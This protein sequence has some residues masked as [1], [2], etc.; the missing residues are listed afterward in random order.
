MLKRRIEVVPYDPQWPVIFATGS[1]QVPCSPAGDHHSHSPYGQHG[2]PR[3]QCQT[4]NRL[5]GRGKRHRGN[6]F[7]QPGDA[8]A[9]LPPT[10]RI[11]NPRTTLFQQEFGWNPYAS[12]TF[13]YRWTSGD[14]TP[15]PVS[16]LPALP[17]GCRHGVQSAQ[18][19]TGGTVSFRL[20]QLHRS[21]KRIH[22]QNRSVS[23]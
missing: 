11:G 5:A 20:E 23:L 12:R 8:G 17:S 22:S 9:W 4:R 3:D 14:R 13:L 21:Q 18:G 10:R 19:R 15:P 16:R 2:D 1:R 6:R 7:V